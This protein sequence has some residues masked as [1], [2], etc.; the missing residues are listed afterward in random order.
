[1]EQRSNLRTLLYSLAFV[2][3]VV[4][5]FALREAIR[6]TR[7]TGRRP[8]W[9]GIP[10]RTLG[11]IQDVITRLT[12]HGVSPVVWLPCALLTIV[13]IVWFMSSRQKPR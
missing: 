10:Q 6:L 12:I 1:M 9:A 7:T 3:A 13:F 8:D 11:L 2:V 5:A 4:A